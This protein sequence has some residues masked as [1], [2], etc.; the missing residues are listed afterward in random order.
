MEAY[1]VGSFRVAVR[2]K[3]LVLNNFRGFKEAVEV[4]F[5]G[6]VTVI[7]GN[8][9]AGKSTLLDATA[10]LLDDFARLIQNEGYKPEHFFGYF[11]V[12]NALGEEGVSEISLTFLVDFPR[13]DVIPDKDN[14]E[15][16]E[17]WKIESDYEY[18]VS[19]EVK[20]GKGL[21]VDFKVRHI[22]DNRGEDW[23]RNSLR[24]DIDNWMRKSNDPSFALNASIEL[25]VLAYFPARV[26]EKDGQDE[27]ARSIDTDLFSNY[28]NQELSP[29]SFSFYVLK[30]WLA[31]QYLMKTLQRERPF[32]K[33]RDRKLFDI[34]IDA[35]KQFLNEEKVQESYV[36]VYFEWTPD[37]PDGEMVV[38]KNGIPLY[39]RQLSSGEKAV[40]ALVADL[41]RQLTL[42]NPKKDNP[43]EGTGVV[44]IDEID[45]HLHPS[46]QRKII[47]KLQELFPN[48]QF[49]VTTHSPRILSEVPSKQGRF[50]GSG[51]IYSMEETYGRE[52]DYILKGIMDTPAKFS[53][54]VNR[55]SRLLALGKPDDLEEAGRLLGELVDEI[56]SVGARGDEQPDVLRLRGLLTRKKMLVR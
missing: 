35:I 48:V 22:E 3:R 40:I 55:I 28:R 16:R 15:I 12:N 54:E 47:P 44:L 29:R 19:V 13:V 25:P 7:I 46:W 33:P 8:N 23:L 45:L 5:D 27:P 6:D 53:E 1:E 24:F 50:L 42:A 38:D 43:L 14:E 21:G 10:G 31:L 4:P 52:V 51:E 17:D 56:D 30:K 37:F 39:Y 36:N 11:D 41:A 34:I 26:M 32:E 2:L 18:T 20:R 49:V 9:G